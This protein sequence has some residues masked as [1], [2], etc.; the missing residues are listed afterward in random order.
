MTTKIIT[1]PNIQ[2]TLEQLI[3]AIQQLDNETRLKI[4]E[5]LLVDELDEKFAKLIRRLE[6]KPAVTD[7]SDQEINNEIKAVRSLGI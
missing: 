5:A 4:L 2:L 6:Q 3:V 1:I 7:I